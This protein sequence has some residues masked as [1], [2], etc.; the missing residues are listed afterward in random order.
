MCNRFLDFLLNGMADR[1]QTHTGLS[2]YVYI[3]YGGLH[4]VLT[5]P[6]TVLFAPPPKKNCNVPF[7]RKNPVCIGLYLDT[8]SQTHQNPAAYFVWICWTE[9][10]CL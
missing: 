7:R 3:I 8:T 6:A 4:K 2:V 10:L 5:L 9:G 1:S